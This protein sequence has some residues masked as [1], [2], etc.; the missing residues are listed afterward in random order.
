[1]TGLCR[2]YDAESQT[3]NHVGLNFDNQ[4]YV[5]ALT[6]SKIIVFVL[7]ELHVLCG[8]ALRSYAFIKRWSYHDDD[9][10]A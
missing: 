2:G 5:F 6:H 9:E 1:M 4:T 10:V 8:M 7:I 3:G